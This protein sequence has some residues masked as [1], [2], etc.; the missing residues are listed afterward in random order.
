METILGT[1]PNG[2][3]RQ[4]DCSVDEDGDLCLY[5]HP[6]N[7]TTGWEIHVNQAQLLHALI[8]LCVENVTIP[9]PQTSTQ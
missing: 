1:S 2:E 8:R 3:N 9:T 6:L 5:I 4:L 7:S